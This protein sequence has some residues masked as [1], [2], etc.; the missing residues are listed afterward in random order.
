MLSLT[1]YIQFSSRAKDEVSVGV[2]VSSHSETHWDK[3]LS[4]AES[5]S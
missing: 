3:N 5:V 1:C 4:A 2:T